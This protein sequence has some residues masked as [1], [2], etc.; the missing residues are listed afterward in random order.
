M[1]SLKSMTEPKGETSGYESQTETKQKESDEENDSD[2][3]NNIDENDRIYENNQRA[4]MKDKGFLV[5]YPD[6]II[7]AVWD[8]TLFFMI[9]Y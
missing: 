7:R 9:V 1:L 6:S 2:D 8:I 4:S 5:I 3:D